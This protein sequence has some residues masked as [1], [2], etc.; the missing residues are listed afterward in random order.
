MFFEDYMKL[1]GGYTSCYNYIEL[2][3]VLLEFFGTVRIQV[4]S[5]QAEEKTCNVVFTFDGTAN[6]VFTL[7]HVSKQV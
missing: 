3:L 4:E 5:N 2:F 7:T 1:G 6:M